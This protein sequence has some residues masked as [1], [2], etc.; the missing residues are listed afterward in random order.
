MELY[1]PSN[2]ES[3]A[4]EEQEEEDE[5]L[6][7]SEEDFLLCSSSACIINDVPKM[8]MT[9]SSGLPALFVTR[10]TI[11]YPKDLIPT[12]NDSS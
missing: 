10:G 4:T 12:K 7:G 11:I 6:Q 5:Q 2:N 9:T 3:W 8:K 1:H